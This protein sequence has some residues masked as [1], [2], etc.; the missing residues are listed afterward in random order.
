MP[1]TAFRL[2]MAMPITMTLLNER[3]GGIGGVMTRH[4]GM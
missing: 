1:R 2:Q 3:D 4:I